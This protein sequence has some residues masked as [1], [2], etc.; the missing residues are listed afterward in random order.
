MT[1]RFV[2]LCTNGTPHKRFV[3]TYKFPYDRRMM[4]IGRDISNDIVL[5]DNR[6]SRS[7]A[8]VTYSA[9]GESLL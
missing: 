2:A 1:Y 7:H 5:N 8:R 6:V 3:K 4:S 9:T